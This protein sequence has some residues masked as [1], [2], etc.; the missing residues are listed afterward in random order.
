MY[1]TIPSLPAHSVPKQIVN[2]YTA[3]PLTF[4]NRQFQFFTNFIFQIVTT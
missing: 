3:N 2:S 4:V 1:G